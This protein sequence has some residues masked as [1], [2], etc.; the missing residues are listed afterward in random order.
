MGCSPEKQVVIQKY[1]SSNI[2]VSTENISFKGEFSHSECGDITLTVN[3]PEEIAGYK[4]TVKEKNVKMSF[5]DIDSSYNIMD[6]PQKAPIRVLYQALE[7]LET[8]NNIIN[9]RSD[10][11]NSYTIK[12]GDSKVYINSRGEIT[13]IKND[14]VEIT[15]LNPVVE[16]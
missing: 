3:Y 12:T 2:Y 14:S 10:D 4:Y 16:N 15:F 9:Q 11:V 5:M 8:Q 7:F 1:F 6:F 13:S